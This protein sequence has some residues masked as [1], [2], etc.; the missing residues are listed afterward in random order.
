MMRKTV[1]ILLLVLLLGVM[2]IPVAIKQLSPPDDRTF[3]GA[4]LADLTYQEVSFTNT[5]QG[6]QLGGMLFVPEGVGPFPAAV[7]IHGAGTSVRD[8]YWYLTMTQY[9]QENGIVV[10][11]P[12][13]RGSEKSEGDWHTSSFEDLATDTLAAISYLKEQDQVAISKIGVIGCSQGG[14][15]S[16]LVAA[17]SPDVAFLVDVVGTSLPLYDVLHY[18]ETNNLRE[19]GFL[20]GVSDLIAY[21]S[22]YII[23]KFRQ[24]EFWNAVGNFDALSYWQDLSIPALVMYGSDDTNVPAEASK[25]RLEKLNKE[26]IVVNIYAGS[27]HPLEDP[28]S[29]GN[30]IFREEALMDIE[31]FIHSIVPTGISFA[32]PDFVFQGDDPSIPIV[33]HDPSPEIKNLYINPGAVLFHEGQF[34]MFFNSF[35]AW[36]GTIKV[37]Y[38]TSRDGYHWQMVQDAP[39]FTTDQIPFGDGQ[40]D[41]SSVLVMDDGTWLM[42]FHTIRSGQIGRATAASPLGPWSVGADPILNPGPSGAWDELGVIWPSV[43]RDE[44]GYRMY[45]GGKRALNTAIGLATSPDGI[46]WTKHDDPETTNELYAESDPVLTVDASWELNK[47]DRPRVTHSPDGWVMIFQGGPIEMRG[48]ALSDDGLHWQKYPSNPVFTSKS[49]PIPNAK[50]WDTNLLYKNGIYYYFMELGSLGETSLYLT[51]HKGSLG[52]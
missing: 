4:H 9:L 42:Y 20:P 49:F 29:M 18:E 38:L 41:V 6:I 25:A 12:D 15:L 31:N 40:A 28:P 21:P 22:T 8:N 37:G 47:V 30:D 1:S 24:K 32:T 13:K 43:V 33:T 50:T 27:G 19:I 35:T 23:R 34:H 17:Q 10:L 5:E 51:M 46:T 11:L 39:V 45:Y 26:N 48:L 14:Q 44:N 3:Q 7:I 2:L 36:P 52:K 16:P